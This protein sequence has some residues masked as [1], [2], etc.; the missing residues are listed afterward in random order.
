MK[1]TIKSTDQVVEMK[2]SEGRPYKARVWEG[3]SE[4]GVAFTAYIPTVQ[5]A[6]DADNYVFER[7][8]AEHD[9]PSA[10]TRRAIDMRFVI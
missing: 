3:A 10:A 1:A 8:L 7:E 4:G 9:A 5:V 6:R 2:D